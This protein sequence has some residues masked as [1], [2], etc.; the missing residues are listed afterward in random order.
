[1][2]YLETLS[3]RDAVYLE[4]EAR[5]RMEE[6]RRIAAQ[7]RQLRR[8]QAHP[9]ASRIGQIAAQMGNFWTLLGSRRQ[10]NARA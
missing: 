1:M 7:Q 9:K 4:A 6:L 2:L 3:Y 10:G 5:S 8:P